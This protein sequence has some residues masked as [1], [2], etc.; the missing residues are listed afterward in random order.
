MA[1]VS[2]L[3]ECTPIEERGDDASQ[4]ERGSEVNPYAEQNGRQAIGD[5]HVQNVGVRRALRHVNANLEKAAANGAG[6]HAIN[7]NCGE[8]KREPASIT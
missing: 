2:G 1:K 6:E 8:H 3:V 7:A 5:H 4:S